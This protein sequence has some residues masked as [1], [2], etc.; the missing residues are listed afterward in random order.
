VTIKNAVP[1]AMERTIALWG[2][3]RKRR[4]QEG[5]KNVKVGSAIFIAG[6]PKNRAGKKKQERGWRAGSKH[7]TSET[8]WR[9]QGHTGKKETKVF[10]ER[11][12]SCWS[13]QNGAEAKTT[14]KKK[15]RGKIG[16]ELRGV[17]YGE[18]GGGVRVRREIAK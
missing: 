14:K 13:Q 11:V 7:S 9:R 8:R 10:R 16:T 2:R 5:Y 4:D 15:T 6:A 18:W 3:K 12:E 17:Q 1:A